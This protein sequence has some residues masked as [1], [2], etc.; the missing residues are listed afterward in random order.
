VTI[1]FSKSQKKR[2]LSAIKNMQ[3]RTLTK[4][5]LYG[6]CRFLGLLFA[7]PIILVFWILK[8]VFW[9]KLGHLKDERIGH[10]AL[11]TDL[12]LRRLQLGIHPDGPFYCFLSNPYRSNSHL[13]KMFKRA[14][15][16]YESRFLSWL[17]HGALPTL[18]RTPFYQDLQMNSNEYYEF[19]NAKTTLFFTPEELEKGRSLL[20]QLNVDLDNDEFVCIFARDDAFLKTIDSHTNWDCHNSRNSDID[21]LIETAKYLIEKG[22]TVIRIGSVVKK[23]INFSHKKMIDYSYSK[24]QCDFLDIFLLAKCKFVLAAGSSGIINVA[25]IFDKPTLTVNLAE[26]FYPPFAKNCLYIPKKYKYR[27]RN[28]YLRFEDALKLHDRYFWMNLAAHDLEAEENSP[29]KIVEVTQEMLA[30]LENTFHYS[31]ESKKLIQA[32]N[33]LWEESG[34]IGSST[35]TPIGISW[36]EKNQDLY[37]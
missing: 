37:F 29:Q 34:V 19:N 22:F 24:H 20:H 31:T 23:P 26:Q 13:V 25:D 6:V 35:K 33:K 32:Y 21:N 27:N 14:I 7:V 1:I 11:N 16:I 30:R 9:I 18:K 36:L 4:A 8:P 2:F 17:Y 12:F 5:L 10:L 15:P 28:E 3:Y